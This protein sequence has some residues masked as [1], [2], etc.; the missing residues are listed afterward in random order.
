MVIII[1]FRALIL[2]S[3]TVEQK[4]KHHYLTETGLAMLFGAN[5]PA[6]RWVDAFL[7]ATYVI[8]RIPTKLLQ[9]K[10]PCEILFNTV[11]NYENFKAFGCHV[12]I[13][14]RPYAGH[15]LAPRGI[16]C[17]FIGYCN[18]YKGYKCLDPATS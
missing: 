10:S 16:E 1:K 17:I 18:Q 5:A 11:P 9:N 8:N 12:F 14:L 13:Y 3:K 7:S 6:N 2:H 15:K 4:K